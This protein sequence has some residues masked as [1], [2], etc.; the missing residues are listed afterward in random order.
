VVTED[1][2]AYRKIIEIYLYGV[3]ARPQR[4]FAVC[5]WGISMAIAPHGRICCYILKIPREHG[6]LKL[7]DKV[8]VLFRMNEHA[9][10]HDQKSHSESRE[11][12]RAEKLTE[13]SGTPDST[14]CK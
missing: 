1:A 5:G 8:V 10:K 9:L 14:P 7:H 6:W 3:E 12:V 2:L 13:T 11:T 4:P